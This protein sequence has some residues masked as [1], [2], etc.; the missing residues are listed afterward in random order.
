MV[1]AELPSSFSLEQG[2]V[3]P[4][5]ISTAAAGLYQK[6]FLALPLPGKDKVDRAVLIW[7]GSSSVGSCAIQLAVASGAEVYTTASPT[8]FAYCKKLGATHVF[9]YHTDDVEEKIV[10]ALHGKTVAGAYHAVGADGAVQACARIVD[11]CKG[12][13][14]VV[15]VRGVPDEGIPSSVRVKGISSSSIF[16]E[17]NE[18]GPYIW[19]KYLPRALDDGRIVAKPD[20][21]IVGQGLRSIQHALD[22]QKA[23]VSAAKVVV[24]DIQGDSQ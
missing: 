18:V 7:G 23:G 1:V 15:T 17:G 20:A 21:L 3:L 19:R 6:H 2:A 10:K 12:K 24:N 5:G 4:L 8:N 14:I 22:R 11:R 13:A 9:D 16:A